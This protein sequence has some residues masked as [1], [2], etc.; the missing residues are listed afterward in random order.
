MKFI[1]IAEKSFQCLMKSPD[2]YLIAF[3]FPFIL[4]SRAVRDN[5][6]VPQCRGMFQCIQPS[7]AFN[8]VGNRL[9]LL[10]ICTKCSLCLFFA[11]KASHSNSLRFMFAIEIII[12]RCITIKRDMKTVNGLNM[13]N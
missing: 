12:I 1:E 11:G 9:V 8:I 13:R 7:A 5:N 6:A 3:N 4:E 10:I 2:N